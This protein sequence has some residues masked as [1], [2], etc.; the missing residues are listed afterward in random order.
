MKLLRLLENMVNENVKGVDVKM[1]AL[2]ADVFDKLLDGLKH[3]KMDEVYQELSGMYSGT[4]RISLD[5][6][7]KFLKK[8]KSYFTNDQ[9]VIQESN[10]KKEI[11]FN[12]WNEKGI[13]SSPIYHYLGLNPKNKED[14]KE[15][16]NY[17]LEYLGGYDSIVEKFKKEVLTGEPV[18]IGPG[19]YEI[20]FLLTNIEVGILNPDDWPGGSYEHDVLFYEIDGLINGDTSYVTLITDGETHNIGEI[21]R[22]E[23]DID[24]D[25]AEEIGYEISDAIRDYYDNLSYKYSMDCDV[26]DY[27]V[28]RTDKFEKKLKSFD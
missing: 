7:Y 27:E 1:F 25:V 14:R 20:E 3:D 11:L 15:I 28:V 12:Y 13:D 23:A 10:N 5:Y 17:K 4:K 22:G 24:N 2:F 26:A 6:F 19:G 8:N 9:D 18:S 16:F 21:S